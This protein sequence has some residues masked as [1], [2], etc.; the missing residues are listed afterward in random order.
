V[1]SVGVLCYRR[2]Y[3]PRIPVTCSETVILTSVTRR[4]SDDDPGHGDGPGRVTERDVGGGHDG[5]QVPVQT[6]H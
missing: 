5:T 2:P 6:V 3:L 4:A 1:G